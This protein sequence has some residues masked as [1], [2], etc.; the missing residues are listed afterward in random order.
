LTPIYF[1][2]LF[3]ERTVP[4][5]MSNEEPPAIETLDAPQDI[6]AAVDAIADAAPAATPSDLAPSSTSALNSLKS[7]DQTILRLNKYVSTVP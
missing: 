3:F 4:A 2:A 7:I 5:S 6:K 1:F